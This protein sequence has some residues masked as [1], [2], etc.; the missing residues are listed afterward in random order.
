MTEKKQ[1]HTFIKPWGWD[2]S[3]A[4]TQKIGN[5]ILDL[6]TIHKTSASVAL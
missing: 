4:H 5:A 3:L 2:K 6:S 1:D